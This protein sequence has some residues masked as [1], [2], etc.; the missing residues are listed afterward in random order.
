VG[1]DVRTNS[2]SLLGVTTLDR[3]K[4]F[5]DGVAIS[6][7]VA[8]DEHSH[9]EVVRYAS[10]S[11]FWRLLVCPLVSGGSAV[12]RTLRMLGRLLRRPVRNL[13]TALVRDFAR[14]SQ[15]LLFMRTL[16]GRLRFVMRRGRV[17]TEV[18]V[19]DAPRPL[20]PEA[21]GFAERFA[22]E[23]DGEARALVTEALLGIPTTAHLLGGAVMGRDASEGVIDA[24]QRVF[25]YEGMFVCDGSA[26][27]AN[28]GVNPSLTIT[29]MAERAMSRVLPRER[30]QSDRPTALS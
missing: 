19:G 7:I 4:T 10:G 26:I 24:D 16:E 8:T 27:S 2:E 21:R 18:D 1:R 14:R 9:L 17:R 23:V 5:S 25:G 28:P 11:G 30:S 6:S 12:G 13:R 20:I 22:E 15:I 29:A 3:S